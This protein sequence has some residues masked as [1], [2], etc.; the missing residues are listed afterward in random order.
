MLIAKIADRGIGETRRP[1]ER[2]KGKN[3]QS[4]DGREMLFKYETNVNTHLSNAPHDV[5]TCGYVD[6]IGDDDDASDHGTGK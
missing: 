3:K 2:D 1:R 5:T 6:D 4:R